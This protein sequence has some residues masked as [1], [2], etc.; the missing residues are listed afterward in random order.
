MSEHKGVAQELSDRD[1][2]ES[3]VP[4]L[5]SLRPLSLY[6]QYTNTAAYVIA[7][8]LFMTAAYTGMA[9]PG[10]LG[11]IAMISGNTLGICIVGLYER[12]YARWGL[13][14]SIGGRVVFGA[15][16]HT[17]IWFLV[18]VVVIWGWTVIPTLMFGRSI[19]TVLTDKVG[20]SG[21]YT[22]EL[23]WAFVFLAIG[24]WI[25]IKGPIFIKSLFRIVVPI[26]LGLIILVTVR[27]FLA[28]S[29]GE[30]F[31]I[32]PAGFAE[33]PWQSFMI[34]FELNVATGFSWVMVHS[35]F[36]RLGQ[37]E[38]HGWLAPVLGYGITWGIFGIPG[39]LAG[40]I[41]GVEDPVYVMVLFG[42]G[43]SLIYLLLLALANSSSI[44]L[45]LWWSALGIR[46]IWS[47]FTW[48]FAVLIQAPVIIFLITNK[49]FYTHYGTFIAL[50]AAL[51]SALGFTYLIALWRHNWDVNL[52]EVYDTSP[53]SAYYYWKGVN[54][55]AILS[56]AIGTTFALLIY[57]PVNFVVRIPGV[58]SV[59]GASLPGGLLA[60]LVYF[61]ISKYY[62][63]PRGIGFPNIEKRVKY[64]SELQPDSGQVL[65]QDVSG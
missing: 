56:V 31:S 64:I 65:N 59:L 32:I 29:W 11:L 24:L 2:Y 57:D 19:S 16:A 52:K 12:F 50:E 35:T 45:N 13:D 20:A 33:D 46:S 21:W 38:G 58:F 26:M 44:P 60:G 9:C 54:W 40:L 14:K 4:V 28:H 37:S 61:L 49:W 1:I 53:R 47:R 63:E 48:V 42:G 43:W 34:A 51:Y 39:F 30:V 25:C 3:K 18:F 62:L 41:A 8:W 15:R 5:P 27:I 7:T 23:L 10:Y 22:N 55:F 17:P 6:N 36:S